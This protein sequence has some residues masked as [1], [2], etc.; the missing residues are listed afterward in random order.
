MKKANHIDWP[1]YCASGMF[2]GYKV[3]VLNERCSAYH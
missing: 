3:E 1:F 2:T